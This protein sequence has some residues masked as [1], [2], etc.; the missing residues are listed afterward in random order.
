MGTVPADFKGR[1]GQVIER[2]THKVGP[3]VAGQLR[4][5]LEPQ[6]LGIMAAVLVAWIVGHAL[7]LAVWGG[8]GIVPEGASLIGTGTMIGA[9]MQLWF[10]AGPAPLQPPRGHDQ[11][12][13]VPAPAR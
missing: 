10:K 8:K 6:A 12:Q 1:L 7:K 11:R 5:L 13:I 3:E 2:T 9:Q 4:M